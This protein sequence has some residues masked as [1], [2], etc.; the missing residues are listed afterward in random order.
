MNII[1]N[2]IKVLLKKDLYNK[3]Y[4]SIDTTHVKE[5]YP[6]VFRLLKT[7]DTWVEDGYNVHTVDDLEIAFFMAYPN[8][9]RANYEPLFAQL[10]SSDAKEELVVDYLQALKNRVVATE[11]AKTALEYG[12][13]TINE[14]EKLRLL[15]ASLSQG[16][17][18]DAEGPGQ[19]FISDNLEELYS[20]KVLAKGLRW[21]L[22]S[23]NR[24]LGSLRKGDFGFVFARPETGKT[25]FLASEC[26]YMA[27]QAEAPIIWFNNEE[28]SKKVMKRCI[29]S[30]LGL[31][32]EQLH[33]DIA[34]NTL[35]YNE[36][37]KRNLKIVDASGMSMLQVDKICERYNP[38]LI[39]F[40]QI[41]K[42]KGAEAERYDL[43]M[44][45]VYQWAR[46]LAKKY[47]PVIGVCQAGGTGEGKKWLSMNDVDS[48]HTAK[49]GEADWMLGIGKTFDHGLEEIRYFHISKNKL[50][51]DVDTDPE[52]RHGRFEVRISP[53][54]V[55]YEDF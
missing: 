6:E 17:T 27:S 42:F 50:E 47:G 35:K 2:I 51:G 8:S 16:V 25:T 39:V 49:Q 22:P 15:V 55:R 1:L 7:L 53:E 5:N 38:S 14:P 18:P 9:N 24:S 41:D 48:S 19:D 32:L 21:R 36:V 28:D 43:M 33:S 54:T 3:Y 23:L 10:R 37:T 30:A 13:G 29:Q 46:E 26:T 40:D 34:G 45:Q 11:I 52:M 44:K 31:R 4:S 12:E 20:D